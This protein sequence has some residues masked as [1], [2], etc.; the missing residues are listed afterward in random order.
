MWS[1]LNQESGAGW[2]AA[3]GSADALA[4]Q[5][6]DAARRPDE[7]TSRSR[8]AWAFSKAHGFHEEFRLRMEHLAR[9]AGGG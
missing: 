3:L 1:R 6:A 4:D 8:K 2:S 5:I 9:I 7:I